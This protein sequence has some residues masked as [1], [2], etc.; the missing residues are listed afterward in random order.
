[1]LWSSV[2][3][4][5]PSNWVDEALEMIFDHPSAGV[6]GIALY[7]TDKDPTNIALEQSTILL[8]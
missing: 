2:A 8:R 1:M 7:L 4:S 6:S 5:L 3:D